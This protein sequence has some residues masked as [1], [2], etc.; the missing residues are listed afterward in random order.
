[1]KT[2]LSKLTVGVMA[3]SLSAGALA[4]TDYNEP[5]RGF[6]LERAG[7]ADNGLAA[8][9]LRS[10]AAG[11]QDFS[12]GVRLGLPNSELI[13]NQRQF[14]PNMNQN[15]GIL[16]FGLPAIDLDGGNQVDWSVY[17]GISHLDPDNGDSTT[18]IMGG[19]ALTA[20]IE[21]FLLNFN[22]QL[23]FDDAAPDEG[24]DVY[25]DLGFGAHYALP[26]TS[27]G[28]FAPGAEFNLTT[29][30]NA[31]GDGVDPQFMLGVRWLYNEHVTLDLAMVNNNP[32]DR[33]ATSSDAPTAISIP[34]FVRLNVAF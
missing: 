33:S 24:D 10:G 21:G 25:F 32:G 9:D 19:M 22:P 2:S 16:K 5:T 7:T 27:F 14:S 31:A 18:N 3:A 17:G 1:M 28:T 26:E 6:F 34:G 13:L 23:V 15:E 4:Q 29:R 12:G 30:D 8:V 11:N 20:D